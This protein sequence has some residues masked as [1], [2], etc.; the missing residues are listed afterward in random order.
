MN[1]AQSSIEAALI[2]TFMMLVM[3]TF[4]GVIAKRTLET[5]QQEQLRSLEE[6]TLLIRNEFDIASGV[7]PGYRREFSVP[8]RIN[9]MVYN[10]TLINS[11]KLNSNYSSLVLQTN[12]TKDY[13]AVERIHGNVTGRICVGPNRTNIIVKEENWIRV[14]CKA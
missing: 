1:R 4:V 11:T 12:L 9:G 7:E 3:I 2:I 13:S 5:Q 10:V 14:R 8:V 6:V